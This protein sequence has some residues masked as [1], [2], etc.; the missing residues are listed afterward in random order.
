MVTMASSNDETIL[1][2][3]PPTSNSI[4][5]NDETILPAQYIAGLHITGD[6]IDKRYT[7]I[8]EIGRGGMGV[9]YEV[10]DNLI[11]ARVAVKR[12]LPEH[13]LRSDLSDVFMREGA[14]AMRFTSESSHFV[15][16]RHL[17]EDAAGLYMVMDFVEDKTLRHLLLEQQNFRL[18]LELGVSLIRALSSAIAELHRLGFVHR[19]LKPENIF[20][21]LGSMFHVRLVDFGLTKDSVQSTVTSIRGAGTSGYASPEQ[22]KGLPTTPA[23]D[24]YSFGVISFE[25]LTGELPGHGDSIADYV[26]NVPNDLADLIVSCLA[27]RAERRPIDGISL[28]NAVKSVHCG[29]DNL[30]HQVT[31]LS[32]PVEGIDESHSGGFNTSRL[33]I[34][35]I[36]TTAMVAIDGTLLS[37]NE[38]EVKF[39]GQA[40]RCSLHV[41]CEGYEDYLT[42]IELVAGNRR[43]ADLAEKLVPLRTQSREDKFISNASSSDKQFDNSG[44]SYAKQTSDGEIAVGIVIGNSNCCVSVLSEDLENISVPTSDGE[45]STPSIVYIDEDGT[46]IVGAAAKRL[47]L[48]KPERAFEDIFRSLGTD[49]S[50]IIDGQKYSSF[51]FISII[52]RK[53]LADVQAY[54]S[55]EVSSCILTLPRM[56]GITDQNVIVQAIESSGVRVARVISKSV[57]LVLSR[58][59]YRALENCHVTVLSVHFDSDSL[60]IATLEA[61]DGVYEVKSV[62]GKHSLGSEDFTNRLINYFVGNIKLK[63]G[64]DV[65]VEA[66][67]SVQLRQAVTQLQMYLS[68]TNDSSKQVSVSYS[69]KVGKDNYSLDLAISMSNYLELTKDLV[70]QLV[71]QVELALKEGHYQSDYFDELLFAG[72]AFRIP[73]V[74]AAVVNLFTNNP[75]VE[76]LSDDSVAYGTAVQSGVLCGL[77]RD[78]VLLDCTSKSAGIQTANGDAVTFIKRN[79]TIPTRVEWDMHLAHRGQSRIVIPIWESV[80]ASSSSVDMVGCLTLEDIDGRDR[81]ARIKVRF[82]IDANGTLHCSAIDNSTQKVLTIVVDGSIKTSMDDRVGISCDTTKFGV[83]PT[84]DTYFNK[85]DG[86]K[87]RHLRDYLSS[88]C[89]IPSG[90]YLMGAARFADDQPVHRVSLSSYALGSTPV[91]VA[92]WHEY[93]LDV[94][95]GKLPHQTDVTRDDHP[96]TSISWSECLD[97][98]LWASKKSG[99]TITLPS[100]AQ[101]EYACTGGQAKE[102]P[103]G[104]TWFPPYVWSSVGEAKQQGTGALSRGD[105]IWKDH[106][107]GLIDIVGNVWEWCLDW[108]DP[109]WYANP[110]ALTRNSINDV[111]NP[112]QV[113][114]YRNGSQ[115]SAS[116]RCIRGGSWS[117]RDPQVFRST[118]RN[119]YVPDMISNAIGFRLCINE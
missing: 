81:V 8:R 34:S 69:V 33:I 21:N 110:L 94:L 65:T 97:Y 105:N 71:T 95:D 44:R 66:Q 99:R 18:P 38:H 62:G 19:D 53:M 54:L 2:P 39:V 26:D 10:I 41:T 52:V 76:Y 35:G 111:S 72:E 15:T 98:C 43:V 119:R 56:I 108:Y 93:A 84:V 9:V 45:I 46:P 96:I 117:D 60:D 90:E 64:L 87:Y 57:A 50:K 32:Q 63:Y 4:G 91:T 51:D 79:T 109:L 16:V 22:R 77:V 86:E 58:P 115:K 116:A 68:L 89:Q 5:S 73:F 20:V 48:L 29:N 40:H 80:D 118:I 47:S 61:G 83:L 78:T 106:P 104:D 92:M 113:F 75:A 102:Y 14:N 103:W 49:Y 1:P 82:A 114:N 88:M 101:W 25:V 36:P 13:R 28:E 107:F 59:E 7:V 85:M 3:Q 12:L 112:P 70:E 55:V 74:S 67:Q 100:E 6:V 31:S 23:T 11:G 42:E 24:I 17:G 37:G 27:T 30:K